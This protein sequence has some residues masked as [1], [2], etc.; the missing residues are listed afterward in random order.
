[1]CKKG[2]RLALDGKHC[3]YQG[4]CIPESHGCDQSCVFDND[5]VQCQ[6]RSGFVMMKSLGN[7]CKGKNLFLKP[8]GIYRF[9]TYSFQET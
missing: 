7:K 6:C 4:D 3:L 9:S 5:E 1:M 2:Y 8:P